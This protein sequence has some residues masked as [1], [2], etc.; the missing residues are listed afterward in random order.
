[1]GGNLALG[2]LGQRPAEQTGE[3]DKNYAETG[4]NASH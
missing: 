3:T 4:R 2:M 1:L